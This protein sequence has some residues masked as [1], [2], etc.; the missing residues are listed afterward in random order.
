MQESLGDLLDHYRIRQTLERYARGIDRLD[1]AL[2]DSV[3]WPDSTDDHGLYV[4][5]GQGFSAFIVPL[6][7]ESYDC[8]THFLGQSNIVVNGDRAASDTY[9]IAYHNRREGAAVVVDVGAGRYADKLERR[10]DEWRIS[11]RVVLMDWVETRHGLE[12]P[13][14][15]LAEFRTGRR[16]ANDISYEP[17]RWADRQEGRGGDDQPSSPGCGDAIGDLSVHGA[18]KGQ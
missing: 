6:L 18:D 15:D 10:D 8:T 13:A 9:F 7:R 1:A 16:D 3:Y 14:L 5:P 17:Y 12:Q 11:D 2:I 4:G